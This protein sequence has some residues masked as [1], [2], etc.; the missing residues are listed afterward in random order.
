MRVLVTGGAGFVGRRIARK[1][2]AVGHDVAVTVHERSANLPKSRS[3][4][5]DVRDKRQTHDAVER[6]NPDWVVHT[7]AITDADRC[8]RDPELARAVNVDGTKHVVA[9]C[10]SVDAQI[11][12]LSSS[13][14]FSGEEPGY[15]ETAPTD[16]INVY[17][18]TKVAAEEAV[19]RAAAQSLIIRTDQ[20]YDWPRPWQPHSM[21]SW[22]LWR[23]HEHRE[24]DVFDDWS[25]CPVYN[26]D[27]AA[28]VRQFLERDDDGIYHVVG[29]EFVDR[30]SW[31]RRIATAFGYDPNRISPASSANSDLP[32]ARPNANLRCS[33]LAEATDVV[34]VT[35]EEG[36][37]QMQR[38]RDR[39]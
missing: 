35:I 20:P 6:A 30:Y 1:L 34:P 9:A 23:L 12:L 13:F 29:P 38:Y 17:G 21:V 32:A 19:T 27:L 18:E 25:N 4:T 31:A 5:L 36:L 10:E 3:I 26:P 28:V 15:T 11:L 8:E 22:L 7:A 24:I 33:K 16:P 39:E 37:K 14:V 2:L